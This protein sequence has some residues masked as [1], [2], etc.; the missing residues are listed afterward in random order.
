M[1]FPL[2]LVLCYAVL[3]CVSHA[4][5]LLP[6]VLCYAMLCYPLAEL[7]KANK[8]VIPKDEYPERPMVTLKSSVWWEEGISADRRRWLS[9]VESDRPPSSLPPSLYPSIH[10][11][12]YPVAVAGP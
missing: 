1:L 10:S 7:S 2:V 4:I 6:C 5:W 12:L 8:N 11:M 3:C 9:Q